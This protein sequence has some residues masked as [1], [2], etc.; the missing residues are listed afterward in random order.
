MLSDL[1]GISLPAMVRFGSPLNKLYIALPVEKTLQ[2]G[3]IYMYNISYSKIAH[4]QLMG[5]D[6]SA[7][8]RVCM[9]V[10]A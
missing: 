9:C 1:V 6:H 10:C 4:T 5:N 7:C 2:S 8:V 3:E